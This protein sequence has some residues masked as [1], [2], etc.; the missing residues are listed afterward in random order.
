MGRLTSER[1]KEIVGTISNWRMARDLRAYVAEI[2]GLV[3]GAEL[4]IT[5]GG[6]AAQDLKWA[7]APR[8]RA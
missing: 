6:D 4:M 7:T 2:N 3:E 5:E 1:E 8:S